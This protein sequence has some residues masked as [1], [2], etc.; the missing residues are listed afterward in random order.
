MYFIV[1]AE[2]CTVKVKEFKK[3]KDMK[4]FLIKFLLESQDNPD[5]FVDVYGE[6]RVL[7]TQI[8]REG[9]DG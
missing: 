7:W 9:K 2:N 6:G 8:S 1:Y 3:E 5:N 4:D